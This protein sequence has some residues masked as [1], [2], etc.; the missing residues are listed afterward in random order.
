MNWLAHLRL[1]EPNSAF[2]IGNLLPDIA[3]PSVLATLPHDFQRGIAQHKRIDAFTDS[4]PVVRQSVSR[5]DPS[6]RRYGPIIVD[7]FYDH[8]LAR[9]WRFYSDSELRAFVAGFYASIDDFR[10]ILSGP[11]YDRLSQIREGDWICSY[12]S[13]EGMTTA[14]TRISKRLQRPINLAQAV[15]TLEQNYDAFEADFRAF[16]PVLGAH[17]LPPDP[18]FKTT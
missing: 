15:K 14:L 12:D 1:S 8:F 5:I 11:L 17:V 2:R 4:H 7:L 9:N 10:D 18:R 6:L 3:P 16:F 13:L